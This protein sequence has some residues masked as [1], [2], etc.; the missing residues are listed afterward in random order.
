[1]LWGSEIGPRGERWMMRHPRRVSRQEK[2]E[3]NEKIQKNIILHKN[4]WI[5]FEKKLF[6]AIF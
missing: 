3:K 5:I 2:S 1:M 6:Y 4:F